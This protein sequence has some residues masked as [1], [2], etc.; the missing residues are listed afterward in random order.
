LIE[1]TSKRGA[2]NVAQKMMKGED[3]GYY[4]PSVDAEGN[5]TW[6]A[7]EADMSA[8]PSANI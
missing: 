7:S 2:V 6:T 3:G 8:V 5:L 1:L 4:I